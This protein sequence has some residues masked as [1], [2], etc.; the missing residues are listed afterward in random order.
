MKTFDDQIMDLAERTLTHA[1]R[2]C[3][4]NQD[5]AIFRVVRLSALN[6]LLQLIHNNESGIRESFESAIVQV[7]T[8]TKIVSKVSMAIV[9]DASVLAAIVKF[10]AEEVR[11]EVAALTKHL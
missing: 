2:T 10:A 7:A 4:V 9:T 1:L 6:S 3:N 5:K 11:S 8:T